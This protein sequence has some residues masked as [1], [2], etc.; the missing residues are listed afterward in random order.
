MFEEREVKSEFVAVKMTKAER[1]TLERHAAAARLSL[2][3]FGRRAIG[4]TI[5]RIKAE[6]RQVAGVNDDHAQ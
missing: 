4:E 6:A 1:R 5:A 2:S 3:E